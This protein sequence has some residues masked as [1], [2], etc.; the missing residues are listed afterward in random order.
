MGFLVGGRDWDAATQ[1]WGLALAAGSDAALT[2][3]NQTQKED[4]L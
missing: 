3:S 2:S 1:R 4:G